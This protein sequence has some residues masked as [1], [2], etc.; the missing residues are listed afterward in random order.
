MNTET[1][2]CLACGNLIKGR[3]DK[4]FCNDHCRNNHNN[5]LNSDTVNYIRNVNNI[6]RRN[7]RILEEL[8]EGVEKTV[9]LPRAALDMKGYNFDFF[10]SLYL[11]E[12]TKLDY[13]YCYEY[14]YAFID[15]ERCMLCR[16][17]MSHLM[18]Q[19]DIEQ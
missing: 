19:M 17:I 6:L 16:N 9:T 18:K 14:G 5:R 3:L 7:R 4:K 11:N 8:M 1:R 12:R 10:T 2:T 13:Y 15:E